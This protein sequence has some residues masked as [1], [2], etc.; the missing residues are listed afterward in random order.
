MS[1]ITYTP[2]RTG[3]KRFLL[4]RQHAKQIAKRLL[5]FACV[6]HRGVGI[7]AGFC[8]TKDAEIGTVDH[9]AKIRGKA[10]TRCR[11]NVYDAGKKPAQ[12]GTLVNAPAALR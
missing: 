8:H 6:N 10:V 9:G 7:P 5:L 4:L 11:L 12:I 1:A 2:V 3:Y